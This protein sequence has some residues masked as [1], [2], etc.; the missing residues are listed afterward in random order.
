MKQKILRIIPYFTTAF[1]MALIFFFSSQTS[2]ESS[3]LSA[4][5]TRSIIDFFMGNAPEAE[6]LRCLDMLHH[7][8]RKCAHFVLYASLGF[9]ASGIFTEKKKIHM[10]LGAVVLC[11]VYAVT[12]ELH[13]MAVEGRAP[14]LGDVLIDTAGGACG[15]AV[16]ILIVVIYRLRK[17]KKK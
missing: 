13:Q 2:E 4:G 10:W 16:F 8:I 5:L 15:A 6:K 12:D 1:I 17:D 11:L 9:S 3:A 14:M 7:L